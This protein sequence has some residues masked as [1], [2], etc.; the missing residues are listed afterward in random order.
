MYVQSN[1]KNELSKRHKDMTEQIDDVELNRGGIVHFLC[2][3][4]LMMQP[5]KEELG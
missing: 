1:Y 2:V 4:S 3:A 5:S